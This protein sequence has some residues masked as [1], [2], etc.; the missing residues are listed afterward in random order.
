MPGVTQ[1]TLSPGPGLHVAGRYDRC[2]AVGIARVWENVLDWEHLP[3]LHNGQF[4]SIALL[5][6]GS[7]G[8]RARVV[9]QPGD[10]AR[11]Q[12]IEVRIDRAAGR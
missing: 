1:T 12:T 4:H 2:V 11:A 9:N 8:W 5:D 10:E 6:S 3:A 7:W